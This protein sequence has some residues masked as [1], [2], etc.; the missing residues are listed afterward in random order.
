MR[1]LRRLL[2]LLLLG[3][4]LLLLLLLLGRCVLL[5]HG[6]ERVG[7]GNAVLLEVSNPAHLIFKREPREVLHKPL[8]LKA[9]A[10]V[11]VVPKVVPP[12]KAKSLV[13][14]VATK[15]SVVVVV[16]HRMCRC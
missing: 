9:T 10:V 3:L 5:D 2:P 6:Q 16:W 12:T 11:V 14:I 7:H 15:T 4:G 1:L 8:L 13:V